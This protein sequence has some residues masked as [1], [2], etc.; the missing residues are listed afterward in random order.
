[1]ASFVGGQIG[2]LHFADC[3]RCVSEVRAILIGIAIFPWFYCSGKRVTSEY[4]SHRRP[5]F[6]VAVY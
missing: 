4:L 5:C 2:L 6:L 1:M 3:F